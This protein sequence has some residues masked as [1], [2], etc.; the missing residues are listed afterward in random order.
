MPAEER[1][2]RSSEPAFLYIQNEFPSLSQTFV[3]NE[4][5]EIV[6][7]G[8]RVVVV[9]A[10]VATGVRGPEVEHL[11][12]SHMSPRNIMRGHWSM[13]RESPDTYLRY[14]SGALRAGW[15][16]LPW[17]L[18]APA[19]MRMADERG[20]THIHTHFATRAASLARVVADATGRTRSVT[21]HAADIYGNNGRIHHQLGGARVITVTRY[22]QQ[23]LA[24]MGYS[25]TVLV[26]CGVVPRDPDPKSVRSVQQVVSTDRPSR[27]LVVG[28]GRLVEKKGFRFLIDAVAALSRSGHSV[29]CV[30]VGEGP[31]RPDLQAQIDALDAPVR[32][33]GAMENDLVRAVIDSADVFAL[34]CVTDREGDADGLPVV[35]LE[36][37]WARVPVVA[38]DVTGVREFVDDTTGWLVDGRDASA[39]ADAIAI[40]C[41][42]T[43]ES[44]MRVDSAQARVLDEFHIE[45]QADGVLAVFR[46]AA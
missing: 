12:L 20:V 3:S 5:A 27:T 18:H 7:R 26:R 44:A 33:V 4:I 39:I 37:A 30:I 32:L 28:V 17:T 21:T 2:S 36:A 31:L 19:I 24:A 35:L 42:Q 10:R 43:R 46:G 22:N 16:A 1:A 25:D 23:H 40:A 29:D 6:R 14:I 45:A 9:S 34:P 13:L 38:G 15:K 11:V 8:H 41:A